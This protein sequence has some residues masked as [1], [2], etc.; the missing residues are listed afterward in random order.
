MAPNFSQLMYMELLLA[1]CGIWILIIQKNTTYCDG[2]GT[3]CN[4]KYIVQNVHKPYSAALLVVA[5]RK[6]P[7]DTL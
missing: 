1:V 2:T 5:P 7:Y 3:Q 4:N 6:I